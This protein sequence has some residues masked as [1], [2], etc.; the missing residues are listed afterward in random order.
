MATFHLNPETQQPGECRAQTPDS[1]KFKRG[2]GTPPPHFGSLAEA[3]GASEKVLAEELGTLPQ[4][5]RAEVGRFAVH[6]DDS[7]SGLRGPWPRVDGTRIVM[8][9][10][11]EVLT[12]RFVSLGR[13]P[14]DTLPRG[15]TEAVNSQGE[16]V[17][18]YL[19]GPTY[20][21]IDGPDTPEFHESMDTLRIHR[22]SLGAREALEAMED[23]L[24]DRLAK[25][26]GNKP[27]D[28]SPLTRAIGS[29][30][31]GS[32]TNVYIVYGANADGS[33]PFRFS[34]LEDGS[35]EARGDTDS[36]KAN[37]VLDVLLHS[38]TKEACAALFRAREESERVGKEA[39]SHDYH[40]RKTYGDV[41]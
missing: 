16:V 27:G 7:L 13:G 35:V 2:D 28:N 17:P 38:Q 1:C 22:E 12:I 37:R 18:H 32:A 6:D 29:N 15:Y 40:M 26:L 19:P 31:E 8:E 24:N 23:P 33:R 14:R 11:S 25:A 34:L 21:V 10:S 41:R 3:Q 30:R 9:D 4:R 39:R 20:R 36:Q 5:R